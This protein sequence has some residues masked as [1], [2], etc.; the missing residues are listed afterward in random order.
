NL[1]TNAAKY[2]ELGGQIELT[3]RL[4]AGRV[5]IRVRDNGM[6]IAP[7]LLPHVFEP[8]T[9]G[10][11]TLGR[12][13]GGLGIGLAMVRELVEVHEGSVTVDSSGPGQGR[14]FTVQFPA[15]L[16]ESHRDQAP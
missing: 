12:S 4:E 15:P 16:A 1:L 5:L 9:E 2:T 8:F 13:E 7:D 10:D 6:G 3:A 11:R 14:T